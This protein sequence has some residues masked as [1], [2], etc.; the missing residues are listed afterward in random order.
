[1]VKQLT[2]FLVAKF[3]FFKAGSGLR[4]SALWED[5]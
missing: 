1:M 5:R 4:I 2:F 3:V